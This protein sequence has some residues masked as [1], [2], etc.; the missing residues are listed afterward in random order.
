MM[1][2]SVSLSS[3]SLSD[4]CISMNVVMRQKIITKQENV[5][6]LEIMFS[7]ETKKKVN[8]F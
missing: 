1:W 6:N 2:I 8:K 5:Q 7:K 3:V 4:I